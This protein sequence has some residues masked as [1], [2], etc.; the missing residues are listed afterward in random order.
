MQLAGFVAETP[1]PGIVYAQSRVETE[2]LAAALATGGRPARAYHAGLDASVRQANARAFV[3]SEDMVMVATVAFGMGDRQT[4]RALRGACRHPQIDRG[5]LS[6]DRPRRTRRRSGGGAAL[7]GGAGFRPRAPADRERGRGGPPHRRAPA[8]NA[9]ASFVEAPTCRRA[10]LL[11]HFG[12][13]PPPNCG[14]CDNCL[15]PPT[16]IDATE[17]ARK[18]LSAAFRTEM[19]F[20]I[21]HLTDVLAGKDSDKVLGFGHHKLSVF[22]IASEEEL[23][24]IKPVARAPAG[25]RRAARR[26][27]WRLSFGPAARRS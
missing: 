14:N 19:R 1:G 7:L 26:R 21:T 15:A 2:K 9:L 27:L 12:E 4:R 16:A 22:G 20:G 18:L 23:K 3:G 5:L 6:G 24:L 10:I 25:A 17:V 11:R 13:S 8:L